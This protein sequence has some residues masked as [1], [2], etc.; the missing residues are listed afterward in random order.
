MTCFFGYLFKCS[1]KIAKKILNDADSFDFQVLIVIK[2]VSIIKT[3]L[4]YV[5]RTFKKI[6][7]LPA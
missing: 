1:Q 3:F 7:S 4:G 5:L 6:L 2:T